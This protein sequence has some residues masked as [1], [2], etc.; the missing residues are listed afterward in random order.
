MKIQNTSFKYET[1]FIDYRIKELSINSFK[2]TAPMAVS[3]VF[4]L[5]EILELNNKDHLKEILSIANNCSNNYLK[6]NSDQLNTKQIGH[7]ITNDDIAKIDEKKYKESIKNTLNR[8]FLSWNTLHSYVNRVVNSHLFF[9][10][11]FT[12]ILLNTLIMS[13]EHHKQPISLSI[14]MEYCNWIFITIFFFEMVLKILANGFYGYIKKA[15]NVFDSII[16]CLR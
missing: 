5:N 16:V 7:Q 14:M 8:I 6:T 15:S 3:E 11:I 2:L 10:F 9:R 4:N 13:I 12:S 1:D